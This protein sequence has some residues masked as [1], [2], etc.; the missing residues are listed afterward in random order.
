MHC[1]FICIAASEVASANLIYVANSQHL[2]SNFNFQ[3]ISF[4]VHVSPF[5]NSL[6][7]CAGKHPAINDKFW[8]G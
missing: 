4:I 3:I 7:V 8:C 2:V 1:D 6:I 5:H